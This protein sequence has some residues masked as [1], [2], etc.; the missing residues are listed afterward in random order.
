MSRLA[1]KRGG[2]VA[3]KSGQRQGVEETLLKVAAHPLR[4]RALSVLTER[5]ASPK[6]LAAELGAPVGNVSYHVREL[7]SAGLIE[8]VEERRRRGTVEHFY[9]AL[10]RPQ[11][12]AAEWEKL[13]VEE[14]QRFSAWI[15]QLLLA[16]VSQALAMGSFDARG[17]RHLSRTPVLLDTEGW[18]E[19][20]E[21]QATALR[22][23]LD[24]QAASAERL[25]AA[26]EE[27]GIAAVAAMTLFEM[28]RRRPA[29]GA[30]GRAPG[31]RR[32]S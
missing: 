1:A 16:D 4:I 10:D 31:P 25:A 5:A 13:S 15:I 26:G 6:E 21:I 2:E 28:P 23:V 20:V 29:G 12:D 32:P 22:G 24:A 30:P 14:R 8:L 3:P 11:P 27:D 18:R 19:L 7:E 9:R 17:D